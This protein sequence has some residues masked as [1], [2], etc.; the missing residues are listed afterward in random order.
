MARV[1]P[2]E[3]SRRELDEALEAVDEHVDPIETVGRLGAWLILQQALRTAGSWAGHGMS[4]AKSPWRVQRH[5][6]Q[7]RIGHPGAELGRHRVIKARVVQRQ[8]QQVLP[9]D[10]GPDRLSRLPVG[11]LLRPLQ[12]RHQ[13]Q[14]RRRPARTAP[15]PERG[16]EL[17]IG[18]PLAQPVPDLDRQRPRALTRVLG[19]RDLRIRLRPGNSLHAHDIPDPA[20]GTRGRNDRRP[21][22]DRDDDPDQ[23]SRS[24]CRELTTGIVGWRKTREN[25]L[26]NPSR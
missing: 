21:D 7:P 6:L 19:G 23:A 22:H 13:R 17:L 14:P 12:D 9:V 11:Q 2:S 26:G 16:R 15:D 4:A 25:S 8:P 24:A 20:A 10:P 18:Q 1:A 3:R 5:L